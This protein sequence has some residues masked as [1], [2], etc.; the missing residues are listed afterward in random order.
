MMY[1]QMLMEVTWERVHNTSNLTGYVLTLSPQRGNAFL[2]GAEHCAKMHTQER[3][4]T[5]GVWMIPHVNVNI[6]VSAIYPWN[7][8]MLY[9]V[10]A[11]VLFIVLFIHC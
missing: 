3:I 1:M 7:I 4:L 11:I 6:A 9:L 5:L 2:E 8:S 10:E